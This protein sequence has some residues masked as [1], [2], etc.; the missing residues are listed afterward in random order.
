MPAASTLESCCPLWHTPAHLRTLCCSGA[1]KDPK[2]TKSTVLCG[3]AT[4][5]S[6]SI[7]LRQTIAW[8]LWINSKEVGSNNVSNPKIQ[9]K[10][11]PRHILV[12]LLVFTLTEMQTSST[13]PN[14]TLWRRTPLCLRYNHFTSVFT[15]DKRISFHIPY[16]V[17]TCRNWWYHAP[18]RNGFGLGTPLHQLA[19]QHTH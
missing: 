13:E 15:P 14:F 10:A 3:R 11:S 9:P 8:L 4:F 7:A 1:G 18:G 12:T 2:V 5:D 6:Q 16:P 17:S 19:P